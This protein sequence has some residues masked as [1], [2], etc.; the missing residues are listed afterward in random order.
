VSAPDATLYAALISTGAALLVAIITQAVAWRMRSRDIAAASDAEEW[1]WMR[2]EEVRRQE[3]ERDFA[4]FRGAI[5]ERIDG[6]GERVVSLEA[7]VA[8]L[9]ACRGCHGPNGSGG[10]SA[11]VPLEVTHAD[12]R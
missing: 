8:E 1:R 3:R 6:L 10:A 9:P 2:A 5:V 11:L 7:K 12:P 4:E